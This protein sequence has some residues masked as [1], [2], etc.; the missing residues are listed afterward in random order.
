MLG[1][2]PLNPDSDNDGVSDLAEVDGTGTD[3][4]DP[5]STIPEGDFFVVLPYNGD[6]A[7]RP[8]RFS[9]NIEIADVFFLVDMTG[10]MQGASAPTSSTGCRA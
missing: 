9:T 6:R 4:N 10:S 2:D 8:L 5:T 7:A 1:T 3:P